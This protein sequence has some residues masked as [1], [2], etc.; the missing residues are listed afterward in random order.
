[1]DGIQRPSPIRNPW[2]PSAAGGLRLDSHIYEGY[3]FPPFYD[4]LMGKQIAWA[5]SRAAAIARMEGALAGFDIG[6]V[7]TSLPLL[8][9]IL[10]HEDYQTNAVTTHWLN[11]Y[12]NGCLGNDI[13]QEVH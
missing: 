8:R 2:R 4:A 12:L 13:E 1:M 7:T 6:G 9:R 3:R 10:A 5:P 11:G